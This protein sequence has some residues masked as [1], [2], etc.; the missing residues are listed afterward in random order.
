MSEVNLIPDD[1][2]IRQLM[3]GALDGELNERDRTEL[4][5]EL[6]ADPELR[7][8]WERL[9]RVKEVTST[10]VL[11]SPP[12]EVWETYWKSVYH[13]LERGVGWILLSLGA[14]IA[15]AYGLWRAALELMADT[16]IPGFVKGSILAAILGGVIIVVSVIREKMFVKKLDPYRDIQR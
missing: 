13:R 9:K 6:G 7:R 11:R 3:M 2:R 15:L 12:E 10:M 8:E 5:R 14:M 16:S 4:D 1:E